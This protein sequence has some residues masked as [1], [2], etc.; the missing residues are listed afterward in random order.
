[1][2]P[3]FVFKTPDPIAE[4][5]AQ[6]AAATTIA[7]QGPD[8]L[9]AYGERS[10]LRW[11]DCFHSVYLLEG[12]ARLDDVFGIGAEALQRGLRAWRRAFI[13]ADGAASMHPG[14][15]FPLEAHCYSSAIDLLWGLYKRDG[16]DETLH[17]A[18]RVASSSL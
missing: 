2:K 5:A 6:E 17:T 3:R 9:W 10:D 1:M 12:L 7:L 18:V 15:R 4:Q 13:E 14:Q 16:N 11:Q 8:G